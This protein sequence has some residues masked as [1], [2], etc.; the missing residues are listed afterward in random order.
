MERNI[1]CYSPPLTPYLYFFA[2]FKR[3][4]K[5]TLTTSTT[6]Q[7]GM[8]NNKVRHSG[9][10]M[11]IKNSNSRAHRVGTGFCFSFLFF[12]SP[13]W[14][15]VTRFVNW[16][17]KWERRREHEEKKR[18]IHCWCEIKLSRSEKILKADSLK[19]LRRLSK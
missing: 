9:S 19:Y 1:S 11:K 12:P 10:N 7:A 8:K 15:F 16:I 17:W 14:L 3:F 6:V 18:K 4:Y 2:I 13:V 5:K